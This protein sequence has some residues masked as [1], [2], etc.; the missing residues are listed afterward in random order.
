MISA[1]G[2]LLDG[3]SVSRSTGI[4]NSF[5]KSAAGDGLAFSAVDACGDP[6]GPGLVGES[7]FHPFGLFG[8][9]A[10]NPNF[11]LDGFFDGTGRAGF[12][13]AAS[14]EMISSTGVFGKNDDLFGGWLSQ[15]QVPTGALWDNDGDA[16]TDALVMAIFGILRRRKAA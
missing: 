14:E 13:L 15:S 10:T 16:G 3:F 12:G 9:A 1:N 7:A 11:G 8:D 4:G 2:R 5:V 6:Q